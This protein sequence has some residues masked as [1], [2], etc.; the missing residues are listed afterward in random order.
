MGWL[1]T[2]RRHLDSASSHRFARRFRQKRRTRLQQQVPGQKE[3]EQISMNSSSSDDDEPERIVVEVPRIQIPFNLPS[4]EVIQESVV[5]QAR[6]LADLQL[7]VCR[8][9]PQI[10]SSASLFGSIQSVSELI[11]YLLMD[12]HVTLAK[13]I[14]SRVKLPDSALCGIFDVIT[15]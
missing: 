3:V 5:N 11:D 7:Q 2:A 14:V 13:T 15:Y 12:G 6:A 1:E 4:S 10:P 9:M 8:L